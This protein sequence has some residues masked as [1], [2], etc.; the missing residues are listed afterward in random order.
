MRPVNIFCLYW[1]GEFR[2][3]DFSTRDV[4]RLCRSVSKHIDRPF[5]FYV[6][7]NDSKAVLNAGF[8]PIELKHN[9]PGWWSKMELHRPD[10]PKGRSLYMDLDS[11]A[12]RSLQPILDYEGDLVMFPTRIPERKWSKLRKQKWVPRYQAATMLFDS[13]TECMVKTYEKFLQSPEKWMNL[14]RSDQ[15]IMGHWL[16]NQPM[17][18][19]EWMVKLDTIRNYKEPHESAIIVTGQTPDGLFRKTESIKWFEP[20]AR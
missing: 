15:D 17:F 20:M 7:T 11:H 19:G 14:Y 4:D 12:I 13:G 16:P 2:G 3:R 1:R 18:P 8:Q 6:L 5:N 10:L 9:W